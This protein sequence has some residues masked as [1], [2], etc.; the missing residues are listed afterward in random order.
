MKSASVILPPLAKVAAALDKTT[1]ILAR[2]LAAPTSEPPLWSEFEWH[3]ARAVTAMHGVSSLLHDG[4]LWEGPE[5][6]RRF[7]RE[8]RDQSVGRHL[9]IARLL[10]A[11]DLQARCE[12]VALVA[13][14]GAALHASKIYRAGERP[15]GDID[16]LIRDDDVKVISRVLE[17]CGYAIAFTTH[18]QRVF[19]P[20]VRKARTGGTLGEHVDNP[21][22]IEVH[23]RIAE[24]LPVIPADIT[25]FLFPRVV[26]A[27]LNAYPSAASLMMHL[28][29]HAAGNIRA[30]ALRL[31]Q[32]HDIALLAARFSPDDWEELLAW[33][34]DG[35]T[36]WWALAPLR[37]TA[38][39]YPATIPLGLFARL[40]MECPWL[41]GRIARR[42]RLADVSWSNIRIE[43]FPGVEWS[44][45]PREALAFMSSRIWPSREARL[46]LNIDAAQIPGSSTVPWYGI[47]HGARILRWVF[48]RP[49]RVQTLLSV[50]AALTQEP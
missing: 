27:G 4:L 45:S 42:Q 20:R 14:K 39:Y 2:E 15:M 22:N 10:D 44:R 38:R 16:L 37:L 33:H 12:G 46:E 7:L 17:F 32:L 1:E 6:W 50:R 18:G 19:Q 21:I 26:H 8:Q 30:R 11:I 49:P 31:I 5:S 34:P 29:L 13:L 35:R 3:I 28:L 43:A 40:G 24:R 41:L 47:S 23:T 36:L 25:Q 48:F 9:Q